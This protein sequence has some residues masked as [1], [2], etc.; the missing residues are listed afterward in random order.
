MTA[1]RIGYVPYSVSMNAACDRR[2]VPCYAG[3]RGHHLEQF[4]EDGSYDLVVISSQADLS[5]W[6]SG[7]SQ[8]P[9]I[10]DMVDGYMSHPLSGPIDRIKAFYKFAKRDWTRLE[11][12][13]T[14]TL[15]QVVSRVDAVVCSSPEQRVDILPY[16]DS[17]FHI[18]D[19]HSS[20][21]S[22]RK[23]DYTAHEPF[24]FVWEG[25]G[26]S[27]YGFR[28]I[29]SAVREVARQRPVELHVLTDL[30]FRRINRP[31]SQC[32]ASLMSGMLRG[33]DC[34]LYQWNKAFFGEIVRNCDLALIP[35]LV[36]TPMM[37]VKPE[38]R[39]LLFWKMGLPAL[40]ADTLA[41]RRVMEAAGL[42][43][44][45]D[46]DQWRSAMLEYVDQES[47]RRENAR[48]GA[49]YVEEHSSDETL[50][51]GWDRVLESVL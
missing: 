8:V 29:A 13:F 19:F 34:Y 23:T 7:N 48:K 43:T 4:R 44:C 35:M 14:D 39:L 30:R 40:T 41:Y 21:F 12:S 6:K 3:I 11:T 42:S 33:V 51:A 10:L 20:E 49:R 9:V 18:L 1:L 25:V 22:G 45:A 46:E 15:R 28:T 37:R 38:N 5:R 36:N 16:N 32:S 47:L 31:F 50:A 24:R 27:L 2:R 26:D 17:V